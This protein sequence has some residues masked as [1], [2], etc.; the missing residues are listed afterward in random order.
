MGLFILLMGGNQRWWREI[1][2]VLCTFMSMRVLLRYLVCITL[3]SHMQVAQSS[4]LF[5]T[6]MIFTSGQTDSPPKLFCNVAQAS[7]QS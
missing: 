4:D 5:H 1:Y 7:V 6:H 2:G 3:L